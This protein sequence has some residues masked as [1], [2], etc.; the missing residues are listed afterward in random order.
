LI[1]WYLTFNCDLDLE[2]THGKHGFCTSPCWGQHLSQVWRKSFNWYRIY[3]A[4]TKMETDGR[5]DGP[6]DGRTRQSESII[7]PPPIVWWGY[8][9]LMWS[10]Q[11]NYHIYRSHPRRWWIHGAWWQNKDSAK[12]ISREMWNNFN[13]SHYCNSS[14]KK[15]LPNFAIILES[16]RLLLT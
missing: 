12:Y 14:A 3:R 5:T 7:A 1:V 8:K 2:L 4:D 6:T 9:K 16:T 10:L 13:L 11:D 15:F